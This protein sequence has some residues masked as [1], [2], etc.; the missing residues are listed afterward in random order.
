MKKRAGQ[1]DVWIEALEHV[2]HLHVP[3]AVLI[4]HYAE[5][6]AAVMRG[7]AVHTNEGTPLHTGVCTPWPP[8]P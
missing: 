4:F 7:L 6:D 2:V 3:G 8:L 5:W 1:P